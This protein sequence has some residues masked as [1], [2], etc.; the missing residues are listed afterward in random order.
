MFDIEFISDDPI[1]AAEE[2]WSG[3][4]GR[5]WLG[6]IG[7]RFVAP[8]VEWHRSDYEAQWIAGAQRLIDGESKSAFVVEAGRL[9]WTAW[10][11]DLDIH[12]QQRLLLD[13]H[14]S[15]TWTASAADLPYDLIGPRESLTE[16]GSSISEW[17]VTLNDLR[18]F[19]RR[20]A[21]IQIG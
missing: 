14:C 7:E 1:F 8:L 4:W 19:V 18:E 13:E 9:L 6:D 16:D 20:R 11:E 17:A 3:L 2:G 10:R 5:I 21:Q 15:S 12:I